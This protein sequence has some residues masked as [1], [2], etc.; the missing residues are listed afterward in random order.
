MPHPR[1]GLTPM[2][3]RAGRAT[4]MSPMPSRRRPKS[5]P[6]PQASTQ[7]SD[8]QRFAQ[9]LRDSEEADRRVKQAAVDAK[10]EAERVKAQ[11]VEDAARLKRAQQAH[12]HAV[13]LVKEAKRTGK[14]RAEADAAWRDAKAE[15]V[16]LETG[17]RP[18][19]A[20]RPPET[21]PAAEADGI[22]ATDDTDGTEHTGDTEDTEDT[23]GSVD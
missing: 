17:K 21:V 13:D 15:L 3:G 20:P 8:A 14:G 2:L 10:I 1:I 18:A 5:S 11:A 12:Q 7:L 9:S 4:T 22:A 19:W 6:A 23:E 16:E